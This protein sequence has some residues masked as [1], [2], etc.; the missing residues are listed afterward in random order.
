M[1]LSVG[2][3]SY[4]DRT[5]KFSDQDSGIHDVT[6]L[7]GTRP[8]ASHAR[9]HSRQIFVVADTAVPS[10]CSRRVGG[11][12]LKMTEDLLR[13]IWHYNCARVLLGARRVSHR[14][15]M[16]LCQGVFSQCPTA[17]SQRFGNT[18]VLKA[19]IK[20]SSAASLEIPPQVMLNGCDQ[21]K[22]GPAQVLRFS[23]RAWNDRAAGRHGDC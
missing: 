16:L 18:M 15:Q 17:Q 3:W 11:P 2:P 22:D 20:W 21:E 6:L 7:W 23:L 14:R 10:I 12:V 8:A 13:F 1:N 5:G 4:I 19:N 9:G